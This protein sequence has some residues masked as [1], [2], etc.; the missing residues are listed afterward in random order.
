MMTQRVFLFLDRSSQVQIWQ[1]RCDRK[2]KSEWCI[3]RENQSEED[4]V[5]E[6]LIEMD[7]QSEINFIHGRNILDDVGSRIRGRV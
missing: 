5:I 6:R 1:A 3:E 2:K 7:Q 4:T